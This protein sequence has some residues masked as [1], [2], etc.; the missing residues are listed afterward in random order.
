M[1]KKYLNG[2]LLDMEP[3][4]QTSH[5]AEQAELTRPRTPEELE[6]TVQEDLDRRFGA[7]ATDFEKAGILFDADI[8]K[9][10]N[11]TLTKQQARA[12]VRKRYEM[13]LR[14]IRGI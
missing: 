7:N 9:F 13:H 3:A 1:T 11:P 8:W 6:A 4:E 2:E 10:L 5:D 12:A 14:A